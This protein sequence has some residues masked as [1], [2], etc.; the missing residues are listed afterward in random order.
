MGNPIV[1]LGGDNNSTTFLHILESSQVSIETIQSNVETLFPGECGKAQGLPCC[2]PLLHPGH[3]RRQP[4]G[5]GE[6]PEEGENPDPHPDRLRL[7]R[8]RRLQPAHLLPPVSFKHA[9]ISC[10]L[11]GPHPPP[12]P[13]HFMEQAGE[14]L[15]YIRN[16]IS[17]YVAVSAS[18]II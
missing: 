8:Q 17:A 10:S 12:Q 9:W 1:H 5:R 14:K 3:L 11:P 13:S 4:V 18:V 16:N 15:P 7:C 2:Q 6:H